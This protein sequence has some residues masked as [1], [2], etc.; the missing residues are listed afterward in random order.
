MAG[1]LSNKAEALGEAFGEKLFQ[2]LRLLLNEPEIIRS[3]SAFNP[4]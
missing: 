2:E 4:K 1:Y 3:L